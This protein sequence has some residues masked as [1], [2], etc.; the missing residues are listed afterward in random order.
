MRVRLLWILCAHRHEAPTGL[1]ISALGQRAI[2]R[3][4]GP[5]PG[6]S[7]QLASKVWD[8]TP[9]DPLLWPREKPRPVPGGEG[10]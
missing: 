3:R 9:P 1:A 2:Q 6:Q 8:G 7:G 10:N 5:E 4:D